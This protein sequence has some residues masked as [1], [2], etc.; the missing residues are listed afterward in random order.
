MTAAL[1]ERRRLNVVVAEM[2]SLCTEPYDI[3]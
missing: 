2:K 3:C 1:R